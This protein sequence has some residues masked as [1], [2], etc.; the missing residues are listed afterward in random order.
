MVVTVGFFDGV[1]IGHRR[2]IRSL[3]EQGGGDAAVVTFWPH[4]RIVLGQNA[5]GLSLLTSLEEKEAMIRDCHITDVRCM[6]FSPDLASVDAETFIRQYLVGEMGCTSIVLG[7][8][9]RFGSDGLD[10][11]QIAS[12]CR[13]LGIEVSVVPPC[14]VDGF[15]VSSTRIRSSLNDGDVSLAARMLGYR[16][17]IDGAADYDT[18]T[19]VPAVHIVPSFKLKAVPREGVYATDVF[20]RGCR[21]RAV[22][23]I[24]PS[25]PTESP[26]RRIL[27]HIFDFEGDINDAR[28]SLEFISRIRDAQHFE[29]DE[30]L[31]QRLE[32]D[33]HICFGCN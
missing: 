12:L 4:P 10:T 30:E 18:G 13:K 26:E 28:L 8:D 33:K 7:Y 11:E 21:Y 1:H 16:Y 23:Y 15:S 31:K 29:N 22:T 20:L 2:V 32:T 3:V 19:G 17:R 5:E 9:N 25:C 24:S 6:E 14:S 27:T